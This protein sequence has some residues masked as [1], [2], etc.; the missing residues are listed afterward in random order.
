MSTDKLADAIFGA[1]LGDFCDNPA[2]RLAQ[3][4]P[5]LAA[6][7]VRAAFVVIDRNDLPGVRHD[8][9]SGKFLFGA[10]V[11]PRRPAAG[12][13]RSSAYELLA[14]AEWLDANPPVD[15]KAV[16]DAVRVM[17]PQV[18]TNELEY[19]ARLDFARRLLADGWKREVTP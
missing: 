19:N 16:R 13:V 1:R 15:E 14:L 9:A 4:K 8:A 11:L 12:D 10:S 18:A 2:D 7:R 17:W 6:A 3:I 5:S